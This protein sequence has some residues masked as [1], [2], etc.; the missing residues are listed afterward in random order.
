MD[1]LRLQAL[2]ARVAAWHNQHPFAHRISPAQVQAVGFVALPFLA[3][4]GG[5][6][7]Q[8]AFSE[9]F[10]APV[11]ARRVARWAARHGLVLAQA[12]AA[13]AVRH[14][15]ADQAPDADAAAN[16]STVY[17][18][19]AAI[20][21]GSLRTRVLMG[22]GTPGAVLGP[23][24]WSGPRLAAGA[25]AALLCMLSLS[26]W[27]LRSRPLDAAPVVAC[28]QLAP[29]HKAQPVVVS[30]AAASASA[31]ASASGVVAVL[32]A[33]WAPSAMAG[34]ASAAAPSAPAASAPAASNPV[35]PPVAV[36]DV[37]PQQGAVELPALPRWISDEAK[38]AARA[39]R[40][41]REQHKG[42]AVAAVSPAASAAARVVIAP[43]RQAAF[44]LTTRPLRTRAEAEQVMAAMSALLRSGAAGLAGKVQTD[45]LPEG[46][47]WR[48][49]GM[50]FAQRDGAELA[51][52][53]LVARGLRVQVIAF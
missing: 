2:P 15:D 5:K 23:R 11:S 7:L 30:A 39:Q 43:P 42:V 52:K 31:S 9:D 25:T 34:A 19:T 1:E 29:L 40:L 21:I 22:A 47:D 6:K 33:A 16:R 45:I 48:V 49:I 36:A 13:G 8:A 35:L 41:A 46:D 51:R 14:V 17:V 53:L 24:L 44:A 4:G 37:Q 32:A 18:M 3:Q 38:A 27:G 26:W 28:A 12:P 10:I 20:D 50:P